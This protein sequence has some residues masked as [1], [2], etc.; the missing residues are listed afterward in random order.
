MSA[1]FTNYD[2]IKSLCSPAIQHTCT[3]VSMTGSGCEEWLM[4]SRSLV[5][6]QLSGTAP[7]STQP[8]PASLPRLLQLLLLLSSTYGDPVPYIREKF[9]G[10]LLDHLVE[11]QHI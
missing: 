4:T 2:S 10:C 8:S 9:E 11:N 6:W 3:S 5:L 7:N 1:A